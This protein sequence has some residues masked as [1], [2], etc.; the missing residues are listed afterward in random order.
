M[1]RSRGRL[2]AGR[3]PQGAALSSSS[4]SESSEDD[5]KEE[6]KVVSNKAATKPTTRRRRR[7]VARVVS[8]SENKKHDN[9]A[10]KDELGGLPRKKD[11]I[12]STRGIALVDKGNVVKAEINDEQLGIGT[13]KRKDEEV[14]INLDLSQRDNDQDSSS[15]DESSDEEESDEEELEVVRK[16]SFV[17]KEKRV[18][19]GKNASDERIERREKERRLEAKDLVKMILK[20]EERDEKGWGMRNEQLPDDEDVEEETEQEFALWR[21]RELKRILRDRQE[22]EEWRTKREGVREVQND[23]ER[24]G[25]S[26]TDTDEAEQ[27]MDDDEGRY[28]IGAFFMERDET[29]R[30]SEEIYNRNYRRHAKPKGQK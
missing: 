29:G 19:I 15:D 28:K 22:M 6:V 7:F 5:K 13:T 18:G 3:I 14:K 10:K 25:Q 2:F 24:G 30:F 26:I 21:V 16:V 4:S 23:E 17:P 8:A 20:E 11:T 1:N 9:T 27:V 12:K